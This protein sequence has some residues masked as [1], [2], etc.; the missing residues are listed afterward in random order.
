MI[1]ILV[2]LLIGCNQPNS[3]LPIYENRFETNC[4]IDSTLNNKIIINDSQSFN[5]YL[6]KGRVKK[7]YDD[8][9]YFSSKD[10]TQY[11][12]LQSNFGGGKGEYKQFK[13]GYVI[14]DFNT[15]IPTSVKEHFEIN[16]TSNDFVFISSNLD[17]FTTESGIKLGISENELRQILHDRNLIKSNDGSKII[18][19]Y[20]DDECFY[21]SEYIFEDDRLIAFTFGYETP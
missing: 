20:N 5:K 4:V 11:V 13:V 12:G 8:W 14:G 19:T 6:L 2:F 9:I 17:D 1:L 21:M 7:L 16:D 18:Y 10:K 3:N 15:F